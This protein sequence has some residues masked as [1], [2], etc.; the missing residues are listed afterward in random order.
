MSRS[1]GPRDIHIGCNV[2]MNIDKHPTTMVVSIKAEP[3]RVN[4]ESETS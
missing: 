4:S 2:G 1:F 3:G